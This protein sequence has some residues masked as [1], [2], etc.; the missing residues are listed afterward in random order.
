LIAGSRA[1]T[2]PTTLLA[3]MVSLD[4][5]WLDFDMSESDFLAYSRDR[6]RVKD[7]AA[8]KVEIALSDETRFARLGRLDFVDNA[9]N[10]S[11]GTIH[12][13]ATVA[14]LDRLLTPGEFAR[15]RLIVGAPVQALLVPDVAVL[16]D[17]AHHIVM[18]LG[19]NNTVVPKQV[20]VGDLYG[21]LRV[22]RSGLAPNDRVIIG[23]V[24]RA[25]PGAKVVPQNGTIRYA[26]AAGAG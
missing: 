1:A 6:V 2:S 12:A 4:P 22:I 9:L 5:I 18:S 26:A 23:G 14:N 17:Q 10:R 20:E 7:G 19:P 11:S 3:T 8:D 15:V 21:G 24:P 13:R 25:A 16:P